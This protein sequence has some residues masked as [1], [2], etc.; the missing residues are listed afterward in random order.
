MHQEWNAVNSFDPILHRY[1]IAGR[2]V[3]SV[4]QVI[5]EVLPGAIWHADEYYLNKGQAVH[6]CMALL[7]KGKCFDYDTAIDGQVTAGRKFFAEM[8]PE[9]YDVEGQIY[10]ER[11]MFAGCPDL[12]CKIARHKCVVD[13]K[14]SITDMVFLQLGG[15]AILKPEV[16]HGM[17]VELREDGKYK[18]TELVKIDRF[19]NE[20]LAC[21]TVWNIRK[22]LN[23]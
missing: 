1:S 4:T 12:I 6:A 9:V 3:P 18:C 19:K 22:R 14:S 11:Y 13:F 7:A 15:Y 17:G 21:L 16:T 5:N 10:S 2:P 20:F 23:I 8:K